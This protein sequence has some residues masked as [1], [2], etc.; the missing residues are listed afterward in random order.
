MGFGRAAP[1]YCFPYAWQ[2]RPLLV[3]NLAFA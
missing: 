1:E 2:G 3:G